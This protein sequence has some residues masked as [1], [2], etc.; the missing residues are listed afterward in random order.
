MPTAFLSAQDRHL[1]LHTW[2]DELDSHPTPL[3]SSCSVVVRSLEHSQ[4]RHWYRLWKKRWQTFSS[5]PE[6]SRQLVVDGPDPN[7]PHSGD[8]SA[9][10]AR[11]NADQ[12]VFALVLNAPPGVSQKGN[13]HASAA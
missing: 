7:S 4:K 12:R 1:P 8:P 10:M 13:R 9:L 6:R 5:Q 3:C 11:L 2:R